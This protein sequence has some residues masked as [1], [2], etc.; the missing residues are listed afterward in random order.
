[1]DCTLGMVNY[2][3]RTASRISLAAIGENETTVEQSQSIVIMKYFTTD[4]NG[5][6]AILGSAAAT[7]RYLRVHTE[8]SKVTR[9]WWSGSDLIEVNE[10]TRE[11]LLGTT[12]RELMSSETA[13]WAGAH[14]RLS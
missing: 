12:A 9:Y 14:G 4:I 11:Q 5:E 13:Q 7:K 2:T 6:E 1:M 3:P 10:F 8:V